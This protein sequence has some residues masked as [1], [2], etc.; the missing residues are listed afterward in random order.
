MLE[1]YATYLVGSYSTLLRLGY[2]ANQAS[3]TDQLASHLPTVGAKLY[4]R[5][6]LVSVGIWMTSL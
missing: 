1:L 5:N 6:A 4:E 2:S 3:Y